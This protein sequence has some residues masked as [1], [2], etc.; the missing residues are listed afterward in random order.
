M[1]SV[2]QYLSYTLAGEEFALDIARVREVLD[3]TRITR[4]PRMPQYLRGVIN[5][6]GQVVPVVDQRSKFGLETVEDGKDTRI[7]I[8]EVDV[9]GE[10]VVLGAVADAVHEVIEIEPDKIAEPPSLGGS[11]NSDYIRGM[12]RREEDF[13]IILDVD[14]I[15][16]TAE[17]NVLAE[18]Q[19]QGG[20]QPLQ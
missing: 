1:S 9:S 4:I 2:N 8:L 11:L 6:R 19:T 17:L 3:L 7:I 18:V 5:L 10:A 20:D 15:F 12:G 14:R 13:V 16:S